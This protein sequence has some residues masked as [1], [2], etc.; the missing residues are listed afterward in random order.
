MSDDVP[1]KLKGDLTPLIEGLK[2]N[3]ESA[4]HGFQ[5]IFTAFWGKRYADQAY[6]QLLLAAQAR[7]DIG[8]IASGKARFV[9]GELVVQASTSENLLSLIEIQQ[10][11]EEENLQGCMQEALRDSLSRAKG[12]P[13]SN[14]E[15]L[16]EKFFSRWRA[17][18]IHISEDD[19]RKLWGRILSEEAERKG[20]F[21]L[22]T[23]DI[24]RNLDK[25]NALDFTTIC[26]FIVNGKTLFMN[27]NNGYGDSSQ[28]ANGITDHVVENLSNLG[29]FSGNIAADIWSPKDEQLIFDIGKF[30]MHIMTKKGLYVTVCNL[31][32]SGIALYNIA[33]TVD[34]NTVV[35]FGKYLI[36]SGCLDETSKIHFYDKTNPQILEGNMIVTRVVQ[37]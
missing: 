2:T 19:E 14:D 20:S 24:L 15:P 34:E 12:N 9:D 37:K 6:Y 26:S 7:V 23:L 28:M 16:S 30:R 10:Q 18:A 21:S 36:N 27:I 3:L 35:T 1:V 29:L 4:P 32:T 17:E 31:T 33:N 11:Q 13:T 22:R 8:L 5:K 25:K